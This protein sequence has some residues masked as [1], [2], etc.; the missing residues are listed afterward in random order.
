M[1]KEDFKYINSYHVSFTKGFRH[2]YEVNG[3][4]T[5]YLKEK[6]LLFGEDMKIHIFDEKYITVTSTNGRM[7]DVCEV[8]EEDRKFLKV[9]ME[10]I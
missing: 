2:T 3:L 7:N 9:L 8:D 1:N 5:K 4:S 10:E 6:Y